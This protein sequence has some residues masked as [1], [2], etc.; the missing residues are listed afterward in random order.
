[1]LSPS[2][3]AVV[4]FGNLVSLRKR[5]RPLPIP[6]SRAGKGAK[7]SG[8]RQHVADA[9]DHARNVVRYVVV[10]ESQDAN[11]TREQKRVTSAVVLVPPPVKRHRRSQSQ[12]PPDGNRNPR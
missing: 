12:P 1:M 8:S 10:R 7:G 4:F 6:P 9:L 2:K 5:S 11:P 3:H